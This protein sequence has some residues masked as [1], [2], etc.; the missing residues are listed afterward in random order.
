MAPS[1]ESQILE[2][3]GGHS[4]LA[5][6]S[7]DS[8]HLSFTAISLSR[9]IEQ[10]ISSNS[11]PRSFSDSIWLEQMHPALPGVV[12]SHFSPAGIEVGGKLRRSKNPPPPYSQWR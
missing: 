9:T 10:I 2:A 12:V 3:T 1:P 8:D 5:A 4:F 11:F 7:P 6:I